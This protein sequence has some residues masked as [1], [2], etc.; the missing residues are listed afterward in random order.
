MYHLDFENNCSVM[1]DLQEEKIKGTLVSIFHGADSSVAIIDRQAR[2]HGFSVSLNLDETENLI[3][4]PNTYL[5][6]VPSHTGKAFPVLSSALLN[7]QTA[8]N[9]LVKQSLSCFHAE[10]SVL[11]RHLVTRLKAKKVGDITLLDIENV[12]LSITDYH[13]FLFQIQ[14]AVKALPNTL[15]PLSERVLAASN[16]IS[17][18]QGGISILAGSG[19]EHHLQ[20]A[21]LLN[22]LEQW[23]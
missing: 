10:M 13:R 22:D 18:L 2:A 1:D 6:K 23:R 19:V 14:L 9:D 4:L 20:Y 8:W 16:I 21:L 12:S 15:T 17:N 3:T 5:V 11:F 7:E